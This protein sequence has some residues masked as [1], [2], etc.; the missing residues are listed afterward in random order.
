MKITIE[1]VVHA[2]LEKTW[3]AWN[4]PADI[5]QWNAASVDWHTPKSTVDL[6]IGGKFSARMEAR[7]GSMGFDFEGT[8]TNVIDKKLIEYSMDDGRTVS[9]RF[10][11]I[12]GSVKVTETFDADNTHSA[13]MQRQGW[14]SILNNF[15][16]HVE[17]Q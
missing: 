17:A 15:K 5:T 10:E 9:V 11:A 4:T 13:E 3:K 12:N 7:D 6:R 2:D 1:T 16:R 8:Y 14:Q